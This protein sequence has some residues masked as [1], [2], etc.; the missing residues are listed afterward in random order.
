MKITRVAVVGK[1]NHLLWGE[2][3]V[4][5]FAEINVAARCFYTNVRPPHLILSRGILK[6]FSPKHYKS[7]A[8][9]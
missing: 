1:R 2:H 8:I 9:L 7:N 5:G 6:T 4:D 3:V